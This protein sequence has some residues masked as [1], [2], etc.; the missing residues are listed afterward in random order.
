MNYWEKSQ[1][2]SFLISRQHFNDCF[3]VN[4]RI[5]ICLLTA[6]DDEIVV[7]FRR[8]CWPYTLARFGYLVLGPHEH[9]QNSH[10]RQIL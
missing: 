9:I 5:K 10:K 4:R 6:D 8:I 2:I 1:V 7:V 3:E